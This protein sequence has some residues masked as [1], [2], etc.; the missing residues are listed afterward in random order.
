MIQI[1]NFLS[2]QTKPEITIRWFRSRIQSDWEFS[3]QPNETKKKKK[4][5]YE[6]I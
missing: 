5:K 2:N 4:H 1:E 3:K 6:K